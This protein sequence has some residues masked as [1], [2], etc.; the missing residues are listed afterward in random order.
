MEITKHALTFEDMATEWIE[1][2]SYSPLKSQNFSTLLKIT[3]ALTEL[4]NPIDFLVDHMYTP[5]SK[6]FIIGSGFGKFSHFRI[7][8]AGLYIN[9]NPRF[10]L[11]K[12]YKPD[13][14]TYNYFKEENLQKYT[15]KLPL[16]VKQHPYDVFFIQRR[17][18]TF[19]FLDACKYANQT[20]TKTIFKYHPTPDTITTNDMMYKICK[21]TGLLSEYTIFLSDYD[22]TSLIKQADFSYSMD[23][24]T[25]LNA[26]VHGIPCMTYA[27]TPLSE[28]VP[29]YRSRFDYKKPVATS[30]EDTSKFLNWYYNRLVID[31]DKPN[32]KDK[33]ATI[34]NKYANGIKT[35][36][37]YS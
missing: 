37:V 5:N 13:E 6:T 10:N 36:E 29:V 7:V 32:F 12:K 30:D 25:T 8:K 9:R 16:Y 21:K 3:N 27:D 18:D 35:R 20:K 34:L 28:V 22:A 17:I 31:V 2:R 26:L 33:L 4:A 24:A 15:Q 23:S 14:I 11:W 19:A 1:R